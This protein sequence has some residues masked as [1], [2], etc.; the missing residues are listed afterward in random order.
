MDAERDSNPSTPANR[1]IR[2]LAQQARQIAQRA[3]WSTLSLGRIAVHGTI[4]LALS[5]TAA[6]TLVGTDRSARSRAI[7]VG[8]SSDGQMRAIGR[9]PTILPE[10]ALFT[11]LGQPV[12]LNVQSPTSA[13]TEIAERSLIVRDAVFAQVQ[14]SEVRTGIITYTVQP[15]DNVETIAQRFGVLPTTVVWSNNEVEENP[16]LL[17]VGQELLILPVDGI[18]Y[19]V[20]ANDT[21]SGIAERFKVKAE[22]IIRSPLNNLAD[23]T[24]L[25]PGMRLVIP[26][27]VKPFVPKVVQPQVVSR[28]A[29]GRRYVGPAP[30]FF[31]S[32]AFAWPTRG[33]IS[34]Y[35]RTYHRGLDIAN[36]IGTPIA[37]SDG[38]YVTFAGWSNIGYGYMVQIDHGNGFSTLYAHLSQWYVSP[39]Q[40]VARGQIIGAMGSTGNS[41]G[42]HLHFEIRY[43]GVPQNPLLYLP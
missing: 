19:T 22:D 31:A 5:L 41:T 25:I 2:A 28:P 40:S 15:G 24:N 18:L 9:S 43:G 23:G 20:K 8:I 12:F 42:P 4:V 29:P 39:G 26:G 13:R 38:G 32:G 16:D 6:I 37:A 11:G 33:Y 36:A 10:G 7:A 27:G 30:S 1:G 21:L 17:R 3:R 14:R 35:F 34:Q